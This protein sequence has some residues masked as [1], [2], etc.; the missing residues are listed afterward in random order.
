MNDPDRFDKEHIPAQTDHFR[1]WGY[2]LLGYRL[3]GIAVNLGWVV[4]TRNE[5]NYLIEIL[6]AELRD[7]QRQL[8]QAVDPGLIGS[9]TWNPVLPDEID[10]GRRSGLAL[11][12]AVLKRD[13]YRCRICGRSADDGMK[14]E[15]DHR[16]PRAKG[17]LDTHTNLWTLC[18]E[19][20]NGKRDTDL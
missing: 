20:N 19:C 3:Q 8:D 6:V 5:L 10:I 1:L 7:I 12:F 11:R 15:V 17:G 9:S 2:R 14:L 13:G 4:G 18:F 16:I